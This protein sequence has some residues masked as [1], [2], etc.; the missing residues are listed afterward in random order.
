MDFVGVGKMMVGEWFAGYFVDKLLNMVSS[1]FADNRDLLVGVEEKLKDLQAR[2]PRIQAVI[3]AAEGRPIRD[4]A[5]AN[6]MRELK[7]AA[8]EADDILDEFE[9]R[10]L[11]D[12]L[13]DRSKVS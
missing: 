8:Y 6:W 7:D 3:N 11:H 1:H 5:L 4:A 13:Q 2:L 9:Y 10:E 12:Q